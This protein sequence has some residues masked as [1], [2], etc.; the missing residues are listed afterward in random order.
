MSGAILAKSARG[1]KPAR[2]LLEHTQDVLDAARALFG[3]AGKPTRL[4]RRWL[5][6]FQ[7]EDRHAFFAALAAAAVWHDLGKA[8][9]DFAGMIARRSEGQLLRHEHLSALLMTYPPLRGWLETQRNVDWEIVLSAVACHHLKTDRD[10]LFK[11]PEGSR[12]AHDALQLLSDHD[13]FKALL[14]LVQGVVGN[15]ADAPP[16][17]PPLWSDR[18]AP[19]PGRQSLKTLK[20]RTAD[21]L[22]GLHDAIKLD[23]ARRNLL[24]AVRAALVAA[25]SVGSGVV[26]EGLASPVD[27]VREVFRDSALCDSDHVWEE[28]ID[29]RIAQLRQANVWKDENGLGGWNRFQIDAGNLPTRALLL[30]PCG[31]GK[32]LAAWRW[33]A[34]QAA[35]GVRHLLF[36]YPTRATA[37]EGFR[38]YVSWAP[39]A[40]AALMHGSAAYELESMFANPDDAGADG[41]RRDERDGRT[42]EAAERLY[43]LAYWP[44]RVFS[45]T[46]DQFLS[47]L[48]YRYGSVCLLPVLADS[49]VV[50]DEVHS[51]D[52]GMF[53]ALKDFLK[54][55]PTVPVLCMTAS[56]PE[57]RKKELE[58][59]GLKVYDEKPDDLRT[60]ADAERYR[61]RRGSRDEAIAFAEDRLAAGR[62]VLWVV[63]TVARAQ[64]L[65]EHFAVSLYDSELRT[66]AG[67]PVFCYHSRF[68]LGDRK[69]RHGEV[70][71]LFQSKG[72][73]AALAVTT[74]VCEMGLD[75]DADALITEQ[76]PVTSL[77]QRMG[78][79][80]RALTPRPTA[81]DV[82]VYPPAEEVPYDAE[83]L[84]GVEPFLSDLAARDKT[85]QS[86]LE[87]A[88]KLVPSVREPPK[89]CQFLA[90][91]AYAAAGRE[92]FRDV[93]EFTTTAILDSDVSLAVTKKRIG[94]PLDGLTLPV[95]NWVRTLDLH[96]PAELPRHLI[97]APANRYLPLV[98][99]CIQPLAAGDPPPCQPQAPLIL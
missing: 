17:V 23:K 87:A 29:K 9:A 70:V 65:A 49:V 13:D 63:N 90:S 1:D 77:I 33:I 34:A 25:D 14:R 7:V 84:A 4:G 98:G 76:A 36:L 91:G 53:S 22:E 5:T 64:A 92:R 27:W 82:F 41:R 2:T 40:E 19:L 48:Q 52:R 71:R 67:V 31:S 26:R 61:V 97:V 32:T 93:E 72:P 21:R 89:S 99:F 86:D 51:F 42:Y 85:S 83:A 75:L 57:R 50:V 20:E 59:C 16:D 11:E 18:T 60:T 88:L 10:E 38:D 74:Q 56:L 6:L 54:E 96:K 3:T 80:N 46:V 15:R 47:F 28:I 68:R 37:T 43:A 62:K 81:G 94:E 35:G 58:A 73:G 66:A 55:F 39:E 30:A 45:A 95:P 78:R 12:R 79:C 8:N 69:E 44:K 24:R